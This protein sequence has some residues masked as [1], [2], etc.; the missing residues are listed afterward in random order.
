MHQECV[1]CCGVGQEQFVYLSNRFVVFG[2]SNVVEGGVL[3]HG[4]KVK[5]CVG[6]LSSTK[7]TEGGRRIGWA[8]WCVFLGCPC[9]DRI[10]VRVFV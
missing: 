6:F 8:K 3:A 4:E 5:T 2:F 9:I 10:V 1:S 7:V